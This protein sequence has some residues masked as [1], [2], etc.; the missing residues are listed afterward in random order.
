MCQVLVGS[1]FSLV[2]ATH[3]SAEHSVVSF[4]T[5]IFSLSTYITR[6]IFE[7]GLG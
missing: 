2:R 3:F 5:I 6:A 7:L 1:G 4:D